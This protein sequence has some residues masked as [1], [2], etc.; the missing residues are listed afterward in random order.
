MDKK[1]ARKIQVAQNSIKRQRKVLEKATKDLQRLEAHTKRHIQQID[2]KIERAKIYRERFI[3]QMTESKAK[4][5][6]K[7]EE[8]ERKIEISKEILETEEVKQE[9]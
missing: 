8:A 5:D 3:E 6:C 2:E 9:S 1:T 7:I 4:L